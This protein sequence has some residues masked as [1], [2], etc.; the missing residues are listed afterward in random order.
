[1]SPASMKIKAQRLRSSSSLTGRLWLVRTAG[2]H[3]TPLEPSNIEASRRMASSS[4]RAVGFARRV[5]SSAARF[6]A[7]R[8]LPTPPFGLKIDTTRQ[9][10]GEEL[11]S[12][13]SAGLAPPPPNGLMDREGY[14]V[15][16]TGSSSHRS[17]L[18]TSG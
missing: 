15:N 8:V 9:G 2:T 5:W 12:V 10:A 3:T 18:A 14:G 17:A 4:T 11:F 16:G 7:I 6:A 1:M 13:G